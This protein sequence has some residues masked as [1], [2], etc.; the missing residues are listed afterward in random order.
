MCSLIKSLLKCGIQLVIIITNFLL[1]AAGIAMLVVGIHFFRKARNYDPS[2]EEGD[3][4]E[5]SVIITLGSI[6]VLGA[7]LT[8]IG[9]CGCCGA[10][11]GNSCML[12]TYAIIQL[13]IFLSVLAGL[14][15][16]L[17]YNNWLD[18]EWAIQ[19]KEDYG[20]PGSAGEKTTLTTTWDARMKTFECC[21]DSSYAD[22]RNSYYTGATNFSVP[23]A[24]CKVDNT[25]N[26][27]NLEQCRKDGAKLDLDDSTD[28]NVKGCDYLI[29]KSEAVIIGISA[30][31]MVIQ[32]VSM[33]FACII[34]SSKS[35]TEPAAA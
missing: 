29:S 17:L 7:L 15:F 32:L 22:W 10:L 9:F 18:E 12:K 11:C 5:Q 4:V 27:T 14:I 20:K 31:V 23:E 6:I 30:S 28:L 2:G 13:I 24:C 35:K 3:A 21:G 19:V 34:I 26:F 33:I 1:L 8:I 25:G 16:V